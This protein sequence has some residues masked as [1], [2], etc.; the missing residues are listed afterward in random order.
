MEF[1]RGLGLRRVKETCFDH[2]GGTLDFDL[3][4]RHGVAVEGVV[5]AVHVDLLRGQERMWEVEGGGWRVKGGGW[6][7]KGGGW[8]VKG[9]GWRIH[10]GRW[11]AIPA[12]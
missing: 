10:A 2:F 8:R 6:R 7:V 3:E 11:G 4:T 12:H 1:E 9:G 5:L